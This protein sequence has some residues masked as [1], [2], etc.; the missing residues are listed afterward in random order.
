MKIVISV[1]LIIHGLIVASQSAGS[2]SSTLPIGPRNP[3]WLSWWPTTVGKSW[4]LSELGLERQPVVGIGGLLWLVAGIALVAAG[5]GFLGFLVPTS[6][7]HA[8]AIAGA[9]ISLLML[10]IYLHPFTVIGITSDIVILITLLW[11]HWPPVLF[12]N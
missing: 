5:L 10:V 9:A 1:L 6:W 2:F 11:A 4:P 3:S 12:E 7:W 8:F